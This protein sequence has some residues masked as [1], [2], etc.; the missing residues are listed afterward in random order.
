[1]GDQTIPKRSTTSRPPPSGREHILGDDIHLVI[2]NPGREG[3]GAKITILGGSVVRVS[4][5]L[6][7][8]QGWP[9]SQVYKYLQARGWVLSTTKGKG[10]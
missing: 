9:A 6:H 4:P 10:T 8:I 5:I 7:E 1:M 2:K 3:K